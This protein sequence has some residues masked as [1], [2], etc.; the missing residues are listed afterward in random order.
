MFSYFSIKEKQPKLDKN[1]RRKNTDSDIAD[2][3][4]SRLCDSAIWYNPRPS[5]PSSL[6]RTILY[7]NP[8]ARSRQETVVMIAVFLRSDGERASLDF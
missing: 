5:A 4:K 8:R 3:W 6:A 1:C 2:V 7:R